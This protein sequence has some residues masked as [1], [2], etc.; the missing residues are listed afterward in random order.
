M[1][2][3]DISQRGKIS[4]LGENALQF[5]Q[6]ITSNDMELCKNRAIK[7][8]FLDRFA[9]VQAVA[10]CHKTDK[11]FMLDMDL[12]ACQK[13]F[14]YMKKQAA[15]AKTEI[16]NVTFRY[17]LLHVMGNTGITKPNDEK[18]A[19]IS[20]NH[21]FDEGLDVFVSVANLRDTLDELVKA[22]GVLLGMQ[23]HEKLRI[24]HKVPEF[25]K[26][27]DE[28]YTIMETGIDCVSYTKGCFIGQEVAVRMKNYGGAAPKKIVLITAENRM[29]IGLLSKEGA[30]A[31]K[32]TSVC[33]ND[34]EWLGL[35]TVKRPFYE[36]SYKLTT[37]KGISVIIK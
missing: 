31:G 8:A 24:M 1:K 34:A 10:Y 33:N 18:S 25:G 32:I 7:T 17:G 4:V 23:E 5:L 12:T 37:A 14:D 22:G 9:R 35:A 30:E 29:E 19:I 6:N 3:M 20:E 26:D 21:R 27:Y 36:K 13:L 11:G 15:L 28:T 16:K 2:I